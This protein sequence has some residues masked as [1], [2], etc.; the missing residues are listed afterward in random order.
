MTRKRKIGI[1]AGCFVLIIVAAIFYLLMDF[2]RQVRELPFEG[3]SVDH[4]A[5]GVYRGSANTSMVKVEVEVEVAA[6]R[7][8]KVEILK[9]DN[10]LGADAEKI[11]D[12]MIVQNSAAV[13]AI[14]GVTTSSQV[15]KSAVDKALKKGVEIDD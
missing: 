7:I 15:I 12:E 14:S 4:V 2:G 5:D 3:I 8:I 6:H 11:V 13:D 1:A 9:H 10:G